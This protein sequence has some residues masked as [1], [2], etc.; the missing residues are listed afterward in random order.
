MK[1]KI[2]LTLIL[3]LHVFLSYSQTFPSYVPGSDLVGWWPFNGNANDESGNNNPGIVNGAT[4]DIDRF[5]NPNQ[6]YNFDGVSNNI[7]ITNSILPTSQC[8]FTISLWV[9][10][11]SFNTNYSEIMC[12]RGNSN[13][14]H[15]YRITMADNGASQQPG[16]FY[17][18]MGDGF[19][20]TH[21]YDTTYLNLNTWI[22]YVVTFDSALSQMKA[23]KNGVLV[24]E[25]FSTGVGS[26]YPNQSNS[27]YIGQSISPA[28]FDFGFHGLIDDIG[29]WTRVL[30]SIEINN[31][32][33][34]MS[35]GIHTVFPI[36][37]I[38]IYPNPAISEISI[39]AEDNLNN[40]I[41]NLYDVFGRI[42]LTGFLQSKNTQIELNYLEKGTYFIT[43]DTQTIKLI[44]N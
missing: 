41:F 31:L 8:S 19:G 7:R 2:L 10:P 40:T 24:D 34:G 33:N 38:I 12:D 16:T 18:L 36:N 42:I 3:I 11:N 4:L 29:V 43:L 23:F 37:K 27:T 26:G 21:C 35:T 25:N 44:K 9:K 6:C 39:V 17:C 13:Y 28:G 20:E 14:A 5:G 15:K 30:D 22:H 1:T 32:L